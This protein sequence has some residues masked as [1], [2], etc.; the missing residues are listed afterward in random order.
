MPTFCLGKDI[1]RLQYVIVHNRVRGG[2]IPGGQAY[3]SGVAQKG[4]A[5]LS[6]VR[7]GSLRVRRGS[8]SSA[9]ACYTAGPSSNL[10]SGTRVRYY[11]Q[12]IVCVLGKCKN[13]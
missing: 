11:I 1:T 10:E 3:T 2:K 12:N 4:A 5:W 13:K 8:D 7:R 9:P 6:R